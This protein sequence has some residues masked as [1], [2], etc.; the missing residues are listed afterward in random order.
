MADWLHDLIRAARD[1]APVPCAICA[2][3]TPTA[4]LLE[5]T[6]PARTVTFDSIAEPFS[7]TLSTLAWVCPACAAFAN[8]APEEEGGGGP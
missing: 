2:A 3:P 7:F 5:A 1:N 4:D 8:P 6:L